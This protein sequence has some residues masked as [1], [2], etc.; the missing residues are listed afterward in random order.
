MKFTKESI[1]VAVPL[2]FSLL[3][4]NLINVAD[5][6]FLG[7]VGEVELGASAIAGVFYMSL[8]FIG[9]GFGVG[10]QALIARRN[11][12]GNFARIGVIIW[13]SIL[14]L[15]LLGIA[16]TAVT[17]F[18]AP[19]GFR[20]V[21]AS[22]AVC[23]ATLD[24][25]YIRILGLIPAF[26]TIA[27]RSFFVAIKD[28]RVLMYSSIAMTITNLVL[29]YALIFG[30]GTIEPLGIKGA[31][32]ASVIAEFIGL[33]FFLVYINRID[34]SKYMLKITWSFNKNV[35]KRI[36]NVSVWT[37]LQYFI[38]AFVWML[39]FMAIEQLGERALA[40]ANVTRSISMLLFVIISA[41]GIAASSLAG[42]VVGEGNYKAVF[43]IANTN[44]VLSFI[45]LVPTMLLCLIF[46]QQVISLFTNNHELIL[47]SIDV[48]Y[49]MLFCTIV[50]IPSYILFNIISGTG[51]TKTSLIIEV[52]AIVLYIFALAL[53]VI[54]R[55]PVWL[56]WLL[57]FLYWF[58]ILVLSYLYLKRAK[59]WERNL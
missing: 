18:I 29:N 6:I 40:V 22:K 39:F 5:T 48:L 10:E 15:L 53:I 58:T 12:E 4:Q 7:R 30:I 11:G 44:V 26:I 9:Q 19:I 37:M 35:I 1:N 45:V 47:A 31:A 36:L 55:P 38:T 23:G 3:L 52:S 49:A 34:I 33:V 2:I 17:Y 16:V 57:E 13:Q 8:Y 32:I 24:Y 27:Y 59:W 14:F 43:A 20:A 46:P 25:L 51:N 21:I 42:N 28:T 50:T 41:F 56:C 54:Y